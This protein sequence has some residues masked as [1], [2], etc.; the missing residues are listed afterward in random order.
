VKEY[1]TFWLDHV[2]KPAISA[3]TLKNYRFRL[4]PIIDHLGHLKLNQLTDTAL[5]KEYTRMSDEA[6]LDPRTVRYTHTVLKQALR[7]AVKKKLMVENPCEDAILPRQVRS[8]MVVWTEKQVSLFLEQTK[9][10]SFYLFWH[11]LFA[12]GLRPQE[13]QAL[14][15]VDLDG[16][17]L[18]VQCAVIKTD[19][20][21]VYEIGQTKTKNGA[22]TVTL[23]EATVALLKAHKAQQAREI[24][25]AGEGYTRND[26]VFADERGNHVYPPTLFNRWGKLVERSGL[27][28][29]TMYGC[30]HT[31]ATILLRAC[32]NPKVV[33]ERL[34]HGSVVITLNTYSH[35][36]PDTQ[37]GVA[38]K[39]DDLLFKKHA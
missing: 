3:T 22:R 6:K 33:S 37:E 38:S 39:V 34:G 28:R 11:L 12:T 8:Q 19:S 30:R 7:R 14:K 31:H 24:L 26:F 27:P 25:A 21:G 23:P 18:R 20:Y 35:V 36:L 5:Q 10:D 4:K 29:M 9:D 1:L 16:A 17:K 13:A 15:W 2:A 32:V